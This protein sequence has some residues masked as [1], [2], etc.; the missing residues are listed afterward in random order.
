[1]KFINA[2]VVLFTSL[3]LQG[4]AIVAVADV[5]ASTVIYTGK[6]VVNVIDAVTPDIVN[7]KKKEKKD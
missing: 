6:T 2:C 3:S 7:K 4:C 1:M 5:V